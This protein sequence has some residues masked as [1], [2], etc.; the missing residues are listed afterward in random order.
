M[1]VPP[2]HF[3]MNDA[4]ARRHPLD[5]TGPDGAGIAHTVAMVHLTAQHIGDGFNAAMGVPGEAFGISCRIVITKI[6][7]QQKWIK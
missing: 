1:A 5:V 2:G 4:A 3:L 6:I 7:Q